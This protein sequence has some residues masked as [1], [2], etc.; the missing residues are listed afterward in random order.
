[1]SLNIKQYFPPSS[2]IQIFPSVTCSA[3][4]PECFNSLYLDKKFYDTHEIQKVQ[5]HFCVF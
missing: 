3:K 2:L 1:M 4:S 5:L